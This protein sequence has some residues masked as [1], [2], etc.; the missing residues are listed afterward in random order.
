M[1]KLGES[2]LCTAE[3]RKDD[4]I[5]VSYRVLTDCGGK[6]SYEMLTDCLAL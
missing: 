4:K 5:L 2:L 3:L 6:E 1:E